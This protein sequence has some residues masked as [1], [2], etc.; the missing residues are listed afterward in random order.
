MVTRHIKKNEDPASPSYINHAAQRRDH[1]YRLGRDVNHAN[2]I[3]CDALRRSSSTRP[4]AHLADVANVVV[5]E[6]PQASLARPPAP[7]VCGSPSRPAVIAEPQRRATSARLPVLCIRSGPFEPTAIALSLSESR[8]VPVQKKRGE[9]VNLTRE[10]IPQ[11]NP[12]LEEKT[13]QGH[14]A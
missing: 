3:L 7:C 5:I 4:V 11:Q 14:Q 8:P 10:H 12:V 1:L 2:V 13:R 9:V 6:R